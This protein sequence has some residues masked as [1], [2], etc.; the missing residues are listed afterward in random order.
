MEKVRRDEM[1]VGV[2]GRMEAVVMARA[3]EAEGGG[4][5]GGGGEN[6]A[7]GVRQRLPVGTARRGT[8]DVHVHGAERVDQLRLQLRMSPPVR[9]QDDLRLRRLRHA[10]QGKERERERLNHRT[11]GTGET[12]G[13]RV[14]AGKHVGA[15]Q[16]YQCA[17]YWADPTL[18][19]G[20]G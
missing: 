16:R 8:N 20:L 19:R 1:R 9:R 14:P 18:P 6:E 5:E 11:T 7:G 10:L 2:I 3:A 12:S 4:G 13:S 17:P 15:A